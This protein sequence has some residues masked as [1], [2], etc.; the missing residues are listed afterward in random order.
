MPSIYR[1]V[2]AW[3][4]AHKPPMVVL[5]VLALVA[6]P[7]FALAHKSLPP[8]SA[9]GL[10]VLWWLVLGVIWFRADKPEE[11]PGVAGPWVRAIALDVLL[12]IG[13]KALF[14]GSF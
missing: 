8:G 2:S 11:R 10:V 1:A 13:L 7:V 9:G 4:L 3:F 5:I 12:I 14:T 6:F